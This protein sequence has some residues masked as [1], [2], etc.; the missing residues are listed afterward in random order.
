MSNIKEVPIICM[1]ACLY[2]LLLNVYDITYLG[3]KIIQCEKLYTFHL[4]RFSW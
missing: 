4:R 3:C 2:L 1:N